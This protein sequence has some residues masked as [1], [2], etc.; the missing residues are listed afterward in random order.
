MDANIKIIIVNGVKNKLNTQHTNLQ[1]YPQYYDQKIIKIR[2]IGVP[3]GLG[4]YPFTA[5]SSSF[6]SSTQKTSPLA[7]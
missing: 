6:R 5:F 7:S 1:N 3:T 4:V 2:G